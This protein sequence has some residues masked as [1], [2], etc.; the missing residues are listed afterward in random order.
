MTKEEAMKK[1]RFATKLYVKDCGVTLFFGVPLSEFTKEE[2]IE[3]LELQT[4]K[5]HHA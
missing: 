1:A 5:V 2:L 4:Y 3:I